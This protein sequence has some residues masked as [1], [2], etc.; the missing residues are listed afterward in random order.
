M[1]PLLNSISSSWFLGVN[2]FDLDLRFQVNSFQQP[3]RRNSVGHVSHFW[4]SALDDHL[5]DSFVVFRDLQLR[6]FLSQ[7][8]VRSKELDLM[9]LNAR[10]TSVLWR[11]LVSFWEIH[12]ISTFDLHPPDDIVPFLLLPPATTLYNLPSRKHPEDTG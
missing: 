2:I 9:S 3:I 4:T 12:L 10:E 1:K 11:R 8:G 5:D 6:V 7:R